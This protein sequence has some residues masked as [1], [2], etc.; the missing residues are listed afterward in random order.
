MQLH[1]PLILTAASNLIPLYTF[2]HMKSFPSF[3][4]GCSLSI[5]GTP[6]PTFYV[7]FTLVYSFNEDRLVLSSIHYHAVIDTYPWNRE[8]QSS[9]L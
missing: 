4:A 7:C 2:G 8:P 9:I 1:T 6:I 3:S 5:F